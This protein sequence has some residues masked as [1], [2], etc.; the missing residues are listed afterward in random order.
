MSTS[1]L[2]E[3]SIKSL[4]AFN[5]ACDNL[6]E[7]WTEKATEI[8]SIFKSR[9]SESKALKMLD[10]GN[11]GS[12][13]VYLDY[14]SKG[15]LLWPPREALSD[16]FCQEFGYHR[17]ELNPNSFE[18]WREIAVQ[19]QLPAV[20]QAFSDALKMVGEFKLVVNYKHKNGSTIKILCRG[21]IINDD[22]GRAC[23]MYGTHTNL[24]KLG[25]D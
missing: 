11:D 14:N 16:K 8:K 7:M 20:D 17:N 2:S 1:V 24:T 5:D 18:A 9:A 19:E 21:E 25:I 3:K 4:Q 15:D 10:K 23:M 6:T 13:I 22:N 12:W